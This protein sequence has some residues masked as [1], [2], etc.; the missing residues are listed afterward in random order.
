M[1]EGALRQFVAENGGFEDGTQRRHSSL[2]RYWRIDTPQSRSS[3]RREDVAAGRI[4]K[5]IT[6]GHSILWLRCA[7][8]RCILLGYGGEYI[9]FSATVAACF[10][11]ESLA[12][13]DSVG[14]AVSFPS[15][16][17]CRSALVLDLLF[18]TV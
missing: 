7:S 1:I 3:S 6:P 16:A 12:R 2:S 4:P 13:N 17:S 11:L 15:C 9:P 18:I 14:M 8:S 10:E 5:S